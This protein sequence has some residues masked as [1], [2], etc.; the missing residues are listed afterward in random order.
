LEG[1]EE[2]QVVLLGIAV[3]RVYV[4][5]FVAGFCSVGQKEG[6][7]QK[8]HVGCYNGFIGVNEPEGSWNIPF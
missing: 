1:G 4:Y 2:G 5:H 7:M 6:A 8:P 3:G